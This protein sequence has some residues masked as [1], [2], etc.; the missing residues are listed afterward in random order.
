MRIAYLT[1]WFEPEPN[2][3]KGMAFVTALQA[4][5]HEV[6]VITGFPNY[7]DGQIY[8]GYRQRPVARE[9]IDG[10][11]LIRLPLYPSHD[12]SS[13]RRSLNFLTFFLSCLVYLVLRRRRF[14]LAYVYHPPI[15]VGMAA[16][17][18]GLIR[19][20]PFVLD[21]Q[22]LWPD[23]LAATGMRGAAR[24]AGP[25]G[26]C[27]RFVYRHAKA[28]IA[29]SEGMRRALVERGVPDAT[30]TVV[31]NWANAEFRDIPPV[32]ARAGTFTLVYGGNYGRAQQLECV[33]DAAAQ[34]G[35][36]PD[37]RIELFGS[38]VDEQS[39]RAQAAKQGLANVHFRGR[40]GQD[41]MIGVFA[42]ADALLLHLGDDPLYAITIP[43][44]TQFYL[45]MGRPIVA[46][47]NGEAADILRDSGAAAVVSPCD[48]AALA[49]A[50]REI[51]DLPAQ[52]RAKLGRNGVDYYRRN[53]SFSYSKDRTIA[54]LEGTYDK[55][56]AGLRNR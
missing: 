36:R 4:A 39:L 14:D 49:R 3:I 24:L 54:L 9:S 55:V 21:V 46:A 50:I 25:V 35:D 48:A 31:R 53:L 19:P 34:L 44:K 7:P 22:D 38:G 26:W 45:A 16:A 41:E 2:I 30:V 5:G 37:I 13:L 12:R 8:P 10:V 23:T 52:E 40:V 20:L 11:T 1:Q 56:R 18:A 6:T 32:R 33:L 43:S 51:A 28:I 17:V 15:T 27:C 42:D 29:Q 47:V